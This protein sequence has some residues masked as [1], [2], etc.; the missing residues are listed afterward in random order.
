MQFLC[1]AIISLSQIKNKVLSI[2]FTMKLYLFVS[3][4]I[5]KENKTKNE[6]LNVN[7]Q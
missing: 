6:K 7:Y 4:I 5:F 2:L 3:I 1:F